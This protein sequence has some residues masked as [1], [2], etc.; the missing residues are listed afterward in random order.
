VEQVSMRARVVACV[1]QLA[2]VDLTLRRYD[3]DGRRR[4]STVLRGSLRSAFNGS[5]EIVQRGRQ[6]RRVSCSVDPVGHIVGPDVD[7]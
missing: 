4:T 7:A 1:L 6:S 2:T 3:T 5:G